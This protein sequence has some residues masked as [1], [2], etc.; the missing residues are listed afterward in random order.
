M[1]NARNSIIAARAVRAPP[2]VGIARACVRCATI[3]A[4]DCTVQAFGLA[5]GQ[6]CGLHGCASVAPGAAGQAVPPSR[7]S[8]VTA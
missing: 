5:T 7:A 3:S 1:G 4:S 8:V 2:G 6:A